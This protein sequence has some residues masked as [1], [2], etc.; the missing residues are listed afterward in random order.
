MKLNLFLSFL[1]FSF[2]SLLVASPYSSSIPPNNFTLV[3]VSSLQSIQELSYSQVYLDFT[4]SYL[5]STALGQLATEV[6]SPHIRLSYVSSP[7][8]EFSV[9]LFSEEFPQV[10]KTVLEWLNLSKYGIIYTLENRE[11][12][13]QL[14]SEAAEVLPLANDS[15][16]SKLFSLLSQIRFLES[17]AILVHA[18]EKTTNYLLE[19]ASRQQM[20][21]GYIWII[22]NQVNL[23]FSNSSLLLNGPLQLK[24][25]S[26]NSFELA[27]NSL[28]QCKGLT[29]HLLLQCLGENLNLTSRRFLKPNF[30]LFNVQ[31][32]QGVEVGK[33]NSGELVLTK[34]IIWPGGGKQIQE[35]KPINFCH[36]DGLES[37]QGNFLDFLVPVKQ[38]SDLSVSYINNQSSLLGSFQL[39]KT[40][41]NFGGIQYNESFALKEFQ[42]KK[43]VMKNFLVAPS[44]SELSVEILRV[45]ANHSFTIPTIGHSN[46]LRSLS[47]SAEFPY[48]ARVNIP[49]SYVSVILG[50]VIQ[51]FGWTK[52]GVLYMDNPY[53]RE[54]NHFFELEAQKKNIQ[55]PNKPH[56]KLP[57]NSQQWT[58]GEIDQQLKALRNSGTRVVVV[59]CFMNDIRKIAVRMHELGHLGY[60][61]IAVGWLFDELVNERQ[62]ESYNATRE[63]VVR[64]VLRGA[65]MLFPVAFQGEFGNH[66]KTL[67]KETFG[68]EANGYSA[69]AFDA[70]MAGAEALEYLVA[71]GLDYSNPSLMMSA[72][73]NV[74]FT[75][76]TGRVSID[77]FSN[78]RAAMD[79]LIVNCQES[80][81]GWTIQEVGLF[82]PASSQVFSF[83]E[84]ILWFDGS[85]E[86]P[87]EALNSY[88]C[89]GGNSWELPNSVFSLVSVVVLAVL[90]VSIYLNYKQWSKVEYEEPQKGAELSFYDLLAMARVLMEFSGLLGLMPSALVGKAWSNLFG[91]TLALLLDDFFSKHSV[92]FWV[93]FFGANSVF[94]GVALMKLCKKLGVKVPYLGV[95]EMV[96]VDLVYVGLFSNLTNIFFCRG[97]FLVYDCSM[98]CWEGKHLAYA[99]PELLVVCLFTWFVVYSKPFSQ[100]NQLNELNI[101]LDPKY[102]Y[103]I[104]CSECFLVLF[105]KLELVVPEAYMV[106][107]S[108]LLGSK[109]VLLGRKKPYNIEMMNILNISSLAG[110]FWVNSLGTAR[111]FVDLG[112]VWENILFWTGML[113]NLVLLVVYVRCKKLSWPFEGDLNR[114][115]ELFRFA[116]KKSNKEQAQK[117]QKRL[118]KVSSLFELSPEPPSPFQEQNSTVVK[119]TA[120]T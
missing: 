101:L 106:V 15:E 56:N 9:S 37:P 31:N 18:N 24:Y 86:V 103:L 64:E 44:M 43:Q 57:D 54:L 41:L 82:S 19:A 11:A 50:L 55:V 8:S 68:T 33:V 38:G 97:R 79:H 77:K 30:T 40:S 3:N 95:T 46:T 14:I 99:I 84:P 112:A 74:K 119:T 87:G 118:K 20:D 81:S 10:V 47:S 35:Y 71:R 120:F 92:A 114:K 62:T 76:V 90:F 65:L 59:F 104:M 48:Y 49:D 17:N 23:S 72:I 7:P 110:V 66:V 34:D 61:F 115:M 105:K 13:D 73:R 83:Q 16:S 63:S 117:V 67:Y 94:L 42:E 78:D 29:R 27:S 25:A 113:L 116:F 60:Q 111:L 70:V 5:Y 109:V 100:H 53:S 98:A 2:G 52:V 80:S 85:E 32:S 89:E 4:S 51:N 6:Y 75:G 91:E 93:A 12:C 107:Y 108:V 21:E 1:E 69:F 58:Q 96:V 45:F 102:V 36:D 22:L 88:E 26:L 28:Q 39:K